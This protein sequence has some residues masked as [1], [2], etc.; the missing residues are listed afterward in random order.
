MNRQ[1]SPRAREILEVARELLESDGPEA[2]SMR[3]LA[4]RIGIRAPSLY[5]HFAG[6][7]ALE[8]AMISQGFEEQAALFDAAL[9]DSPQPIVA[10][11]E[12][13]RE[14]ARVHP[15]LYRLMYDSSL[16]RSRLNPGSEDRAAAPA[17]GAMGGDRDLARALF[18]FAHG[19]TI[20]ELN[21]RFLPGADL[22]A[23]WRR[24]LAGLQASIPAEAMEDD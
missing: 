14:F 7:Q 23:A 10:M 8:A 15:H 6:K 1:L 5:K 12:A 22:D 17:I 4:E 19:M 2:L 20:L 18:A 9:A 21:E 16:D 3:K 11:A 13:Y 24:G